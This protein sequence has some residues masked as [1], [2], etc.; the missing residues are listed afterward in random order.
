MTLLTWKK[1]YS[2]GVPAVDH[3]HEELIQLINDLHAKV[4]EGGST[5]AIP[6]F[7]GEI[8][9]QIAAHF[10]LEERIMREHGYDEYPEHKADHQDLLDG[11]RDLMD[12]YEL[13]GN[14]NEAALA[15][16]LQ[17]GVLRQNGERHD[18]QRHGDDL[19]IRDDQHAQEEG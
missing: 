8:Y 7:L 17:L 5:E 18:G 6:E 19:Q 4:E 1:E 11:L 12:D 13:L 2:V 15:K 16:R 3:E 10:A 9:A 14:F